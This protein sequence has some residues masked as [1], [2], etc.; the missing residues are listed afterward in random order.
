MPMGMGVRSNVND[1][2]DDPAGFVYHRK[3]E[4]IVEKITCHRVKTF[5]DK[6]PSELDNAVNAFL[7]EMEVK[8]RSFEVI[9]IMFKGG[10][11]RHSAC[12]G[13]NAAESY[14]FYYAQIH[15][16]YDRPIKINESD[17]E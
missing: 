13:N 9:D 2:V 11:Q 15:Y 3:K 17:E 10:L 8:Y 5:G 12:V 1:H 4:A 16:R 7:E 14:P 6:D